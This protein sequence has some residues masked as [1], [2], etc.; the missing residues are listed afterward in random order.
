MGAS[1]YYI[2]RAGL[3][4][5]S[6]TDIPIIGRAVQWGNDRLQAAV[7]GIVRRYAE[8]ERAARE[9]PAI[10]EDARHIVSVMQRT[11]TPNQVM[12]AMQYQRKADE[13][14]SEVANRGPVDTVMEW[15]ASLKRATGMGALPL[16]PAAVAV[17]AGV[18]AVVIANAIKYRSEAQLIRDA[19]AAG[20]TPEQ[21]AQIATRGSPFKSGLFGFT[22]A[23]TV[24]GVGLGAYLLIN[25]LRGSGARR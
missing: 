19:I 11:G 7:E 3:G 5:I 12:Q 22:T 23:V 1:A 9:A 18:A 13:L 21:I 6:V 17:A 25:A 20:L 8:F 14:V 15:L 10:A 16:V 2:K 4:A 24:I